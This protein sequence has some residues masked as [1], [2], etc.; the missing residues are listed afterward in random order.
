[1]ASPSAGPQ[2]EKPVIAVFNS[3]D[4]TVELLRTYL[5]EQQGSRRWLGISRM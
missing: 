5:E 1:M 2:A 4:D 3:S